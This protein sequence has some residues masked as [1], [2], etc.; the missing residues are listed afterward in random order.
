MKYFLGFYSAESLGAKS[1]LQN[2]KNTLSRYNVLNCIAQIY[3]GASVMSGNLN[4][5][6]ALLW[7]ERPQA[8]YIHC[9]SHRLNLVLLMYAKET[10]MH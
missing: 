6:Q 1:F 10:C 8:L 5:V 7:K 2:M 4:G 3:D 9:F